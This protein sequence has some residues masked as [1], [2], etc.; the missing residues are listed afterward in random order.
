QTDWPVNNPANGQNQGYTEGC[1]DLGGFLFIPTVGD[2]TRVS[3]TAGPDFWEG[4]FHWNQLLSS[5]FLD[6][7]LFPDGRAQPY[8]YE[9]TQGMVGV[10]QNFTISYREAG[11]TI[12]LFLFSTHTNLLSQYTQEELDKL[13]GLGPFIPEGVASAGLTNSVPD[14]I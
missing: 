13:F 7:T 3:H 14:R 9:V 1:C 5:Q 2:P 11:V 4:N 10:P 12:D 6:A 8:K